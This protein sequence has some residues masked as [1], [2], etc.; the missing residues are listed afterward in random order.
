MDDTHEAKPADNRTRDQHLSDVTATA[1]ENVR[2]LI[3]LSSVLAAQLELIANRRREVEPFYELPK[4]L[5]T[6]TGIPWLY[7]DAR[8][9]LRD[10]ASTLPIRGLDFGVADGDDW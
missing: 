5:Y 3:F 9:G 6:V 7:R 1:L 10:I 8:E 2:Q 4:S